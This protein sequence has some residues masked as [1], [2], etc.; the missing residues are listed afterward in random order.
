MKKICVGS[1]VVFV[2]M[3]GLA[4][5][6]TQKST[7]TNA[8]A[9]KKQS[10]RFADKLLKFF[11]IADS[12]GTLKGPNEIRTGQ[13]WVA[14]LG[15][16]SSRAIT[17][18]GGYR[19]PIFIASSKDI[20]VLKEGEI[21]RFSAGSSQGKR[22]YPA[23]GITKL[24]ASS[25][26]DADEVLVL[27]SDGSGGH[28]RVG[29]LSISTGKVTQEPYDPT[30]SQDLQKVENLESWDRVYGEKRIYVKRESKQAM[31]GL[32][33]WTDV[34]QRAS[35]GETVNVSQCDGANCGQPS[36]SSDGRLIVFVK[37]E[38]E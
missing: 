12:P 31:S 34:F 22:L 15:S 7:D 20:L 6:Q 13:L 3:A 19:S 26:D 30:S 4:V 18:S 27:Q 1:C 24:V 29:S 5:G 23:N 38:R 14:E 32:V 28:P 25:S 17:E 36:M 10:T 33:E 16:K 2:F 35:S 8:V 37:A 21:L 9:K 11:G